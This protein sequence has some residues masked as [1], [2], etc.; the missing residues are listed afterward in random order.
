MN[1][2]LLSR[3]VLAVAALGVGSAVLAAV[4]ATAATSDVTRGQVLTATTALRAEPDPD[5]GTFSPA[6][7]KA[8]RVLAN[9][10]CSVDQDSELH[11]TSVGATV[12]QNPVVDGLVVTAVIYP[13]DLLQGSGGLPRIC[14]FAALATVNGNYSLN[15]SATLTAGRSSTSQLS[16]HVFVT[17][18]INNA[19]DQPADSM[20]VSAA[21]R[22]GMIITT[23]TPTKVSTPKTS[24]EKKAAK[25]AYAK[26][27]KSARKAY[28]KAGRTATAK[29]AYAK[30]KASAMAAYKKA[31]ATS[32]IVN[33]TKTQT[34]SRPFAV[35]ARRSFSE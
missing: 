7:N 19:Y 20:E 22:A 14:T 9:R 5:P 16:G 10:A 30:K 12:E 24:A 11:F 26:K 31:I 28:D 17:R 8:V 4:P 3:S 27:L 18:P 35:S 1:T 32:R 2:T 29:K 6:T 23:T 25:R 13:A 34:E 21:G 15:G 33:V